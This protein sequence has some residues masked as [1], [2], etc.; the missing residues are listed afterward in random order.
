[1]HEVGDVHG[2]GP[3]A[4]RKLREDR[5]EA[6]PQGLEALPGEDGPADN[7]VPLV[8]VSGDFIGAQAL[9]RFFGGF[10]DHGVRG[11]PAVFPA[12]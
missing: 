12:Q 7:Q 11:C 10:G 8:P 1:M 3:L 5:L 4:R 2:L 9:R 6:A